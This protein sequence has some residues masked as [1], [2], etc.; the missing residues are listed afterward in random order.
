MVGCKAFV[1]SRTAFY[2]Y[3]F[4]EQLANDIEEIKCTNKLIVPA[5]TTCNLYKVEQEDYKKFLRDNITKTYK[6][7]TNSKSNRVNFDEEK[8]A[9]KLLI[10]EL[11]KN[12]MHI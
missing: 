6:K 8:V 3:I 12:L 11:I 1:V 7:S 9:E 10:S 2:F 5:D 4:D